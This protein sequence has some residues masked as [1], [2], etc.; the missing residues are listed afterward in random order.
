MLEIKVTYFPTDDSEVGPLCISEC[1]PAEALVDSPSALPGDV[2]KKLALI[3]YANSREFKKEFDELQATR[4]SRLSVELSHSH[5]SNQLNK[6]INASDAALF[7]FYVTY[8]IGSNLAKRYSVV[9]AKCIEEARDA[10]FAACGSMFC[11][12]YT[13]EEFKGQAEAYGLSLVALQ[14]Q[15]YL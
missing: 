11:N 10:A 9:L 1:I 5:V 8:G 12:L 7:P 13:E 6:K 2:T 3:L 14:P 4:A 15:R